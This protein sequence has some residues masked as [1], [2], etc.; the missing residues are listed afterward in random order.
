V[1]YK[2]MFKG[3]FIAAVEIPDGREVTMT[4]RA[5]EIVPIED[6]RGEI[7]Q[8]PV[9]SLAGT[10]RGWVLNRT[11]A[12]LV[13]AMFG[14]ETDDWAGKRVTLRSEV[15][16]FGRERVPGIRVCGSPDLRRDL[17]ATVKL[18]RKRPSEVTLRRTGSSRAPEPAGGDRPDD[19]HDGGAPDGGEE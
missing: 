10:D 3:R 15:V 8:R 18:P 7:R 17:R 4:I 5:V 6:E 2:A 1:N 12:E 16:Q 14:A 19:V 13:A 9:V 11:N